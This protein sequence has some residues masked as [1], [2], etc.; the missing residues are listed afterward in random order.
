MSK[1]KIYILKNAGI[2]LS[3]GIKYLTKVEMNHILT[4]S[5]WKGI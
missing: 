5:F 3:N 4:L 2:D 1:T